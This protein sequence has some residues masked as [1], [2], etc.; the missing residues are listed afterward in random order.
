RHPRLQLLSVRSSGRRFETDALAE[1]VLPRIVLRG[2]S[3]VDDDRFRAGVAVALAQ[4]SSLSRGHAERVEVTFA[5]VHR[6]HLGHFLWVCLRTPLEFNATRAGAATGRRAVNSRTGDTGNR[7]QVWQQRL[8]EEP[9]L[10]R[11][12]IL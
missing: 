10:L 3:R 1:D 7:R 11:C 4:Q 9:A 2:K 8:V 5:D 6:R 12:W